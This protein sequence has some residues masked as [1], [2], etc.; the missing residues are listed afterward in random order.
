L[1]DVVVKTAAAFANSH[2]GTLLIGVADNGGVL[3][4]MPDFRSLGD[5]DRDKFEIHLRNIL[6]Q[7]MGAAFVAT[8][9]A[10][11]F[12]ELEGKDVCQVDVS[13]ATQLIAVHTKD[14]SGRD[15]ERLYARSGN[16]SPEIPL[17]EVGAYIKKRFPA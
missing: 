10:I 11:M 12:H 17:S 4:L 6:T 1:E 8:K 15:I 3:G 7:Q 2:G 14:K 9:I 16:S 5:A 13:P